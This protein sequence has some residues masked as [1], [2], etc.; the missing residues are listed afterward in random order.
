MSNDSVEKFYE[1]QPEAGPMPEAPME[2]L[3]PVEMPMPAEMPEAGAVDL[4]AESL[5][6][7]IE[8]PDYPGGRGGM[9]AV[10]MPSGDPAEVYAAAATPIGNR[11]PEMEM[12]G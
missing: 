8:M 5:A 3:A 7:A 6:P 11:P 10:P 1:G 2:A 9:D 12:P 4:A